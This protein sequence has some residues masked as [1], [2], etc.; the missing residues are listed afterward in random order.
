MRVSERQTTVPTPFDNDLF[1]WPKSLDCLLLMH[2]FTFGQER[3]VKAFCR[4][5]R[6]WE[7]SVRLRMLCAD[8][9]L[10]ELLGGNVTQF[11]SF[12]SMPRQYPLFAQI[13]ELNYV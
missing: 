6:V 12:A 13:V 5:G 7:K 9:D 4:L 1:K 8:R 10:H 11:K 3:I 2:A